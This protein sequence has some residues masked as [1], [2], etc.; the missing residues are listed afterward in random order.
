MRSASSARLISGSDHEDTNMM[1]SDYDVSRASAE[2]RDAMQDR[3]AEQ[4]HQ[5][6]NCCSAMFQIYQRCKW[7]GDSR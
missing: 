2:T 6:E 7:C 3:C 4:G 5:Y 1:K